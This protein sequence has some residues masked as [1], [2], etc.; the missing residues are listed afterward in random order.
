M[1]LTGNKPDFEEKIVE[2]LTEVITKAIFD[3]M[4]L[5]MRLDRHFWTF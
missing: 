5:K 2:R 1:N 3:Q 4:G